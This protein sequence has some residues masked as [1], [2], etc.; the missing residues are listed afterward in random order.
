VTARIFPLADAQQAHEFMAKT[1]HIGKI[2][3][4]LD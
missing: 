1:G 4:K 3:L 2:L